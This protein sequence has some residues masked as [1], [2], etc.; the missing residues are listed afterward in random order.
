MTNYTS[1]RARLREGRRH[2][3]PVRLG[4]MENIF[5]A[6]AAA[7]RRTMRVFFVHPSLSLSLCARNFRILFSKGKQIIP[8]T[9]YVY[10]PKFPKFRPIVV[11]RR[12][13]VYIRLYSQKQQRQPVMAAN[14]NSV[15]RRR[16][17]RRHG[18]RGA[19]CATTDNNINR[20]RRQLAEMV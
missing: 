5:S 11:R 4:G 2:R 12:A 6:T 19:L 17:R 16:N 13:M 15:N 20:R 10:D 1:G 14:K 7:G 8:F 9:V 18:A 3:R